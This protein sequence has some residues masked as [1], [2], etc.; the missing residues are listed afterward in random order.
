MA[1]AGVGE[2]CPR[3]CA[4]EP[5]SERMFLCTKWVMFDQHQVH[6]C[7]PLVRSARAMRCACLRHP[8]SFMNQCGRAWVLGRGR[9]CALAHGVHLQRRPQW[10]AHTGTCQQPEPTAPP[11][12]MEEVTIVVIIGVY[13][14]MHTEHTYSALILCAWMHAR[15][16]R[17]ACSS[18]GAGACAR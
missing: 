1:A 2:P 13:S 9:G 5:H 3:T 14:P 12:P 7:A 4:H 10:C 8:G 15:T 17:R 18:R 11:L 6:V 16:D